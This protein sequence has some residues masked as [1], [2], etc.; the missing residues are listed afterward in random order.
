MLSD[1]GRF[2]WPWF[3][4]ASNTVGRVELNHRDFVN[5]VFRQFKKPP[6]ED[7]FW[8]LV[9]E[10]HE[11]YLMF[12]YEI[13]GKVWGQWW[14]S[15]KYLPKYKIRRDEKT[16]A[17]IV[18]EFTRWQGEYENRKLHAIHG[19]C[20]VL[21][22]SENFQ[23]SMKTSGEFPLG[24]IGIEIVI[25]SE[26]ETEE[27]S[28]PYAPHGAFDLTFQNGNGNGGGHP[29]KPKSGKRSTEEIKKALG[30]RLV[31]WVEFRKVY[32]CQESMNPAM[33]A[34]ERKVKTRDMAEAVYRGAKAYAAKCAADPTL[35]LK[36]AQGWIND[37]RWTDEIIVRDVVKTKQ[38]I[39]ADE[40]NLA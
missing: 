15:E 5:T 7:E 31:W 17:P 4:C 8:A 11:S 2:A 24:E 19:K 36:Y 32:P 18:R 40:W 1:A 21:N 35:K 33:D 9:S 25:G 34:Y 29:K 28:K 22:V 6:T 13:A 27:K 26:I 20:R 23:N 14:V 38:Q 30:D 12:V 39:Q 37:E 3:W 10:F 16:P